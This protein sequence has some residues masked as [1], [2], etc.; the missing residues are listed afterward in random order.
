VSIFDL[1]LFYSFE[2]FSLFVLK[3]KLNTERIKLKAAFKPKYQ[4]TNAEEELEH[5]FNFFLIFIHFQNDFARIF[6]A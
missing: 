6:N 1:L 4:Q 2:C 3:L 5:V